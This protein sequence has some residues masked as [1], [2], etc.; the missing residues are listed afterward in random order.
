MSV[1]IRGGN[2]K[3]N[4]QATAYETAKPTYESHVCPHFP[5]PGSFVS[6]AKPA[7]VTLQP[8]LRKFGLGARHGCSGESSRH[9]ARN[10]VPLPTRP[11]PCRSLERE[12]PRG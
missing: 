10:P 12:W 4:C 6:K 7:V 11:S 5:V 8:Q 9:P 3:Q 2:T 1:R